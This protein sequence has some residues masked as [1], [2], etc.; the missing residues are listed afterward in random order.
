MNDKS[1]NWKQV[2]IN[3]ETKSKLDA[4]CEALSTEYARVTFAGMLDKLINDK[5]NEVFTDKK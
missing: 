2:N 1:R 4:I 3:V 5:Y